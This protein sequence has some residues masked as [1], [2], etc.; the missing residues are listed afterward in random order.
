[1]RRIHK[2]L[3]AALKKR[4]AARFKIIKGL[5]KEIYNEGISVGL[6]ARREIT[7]KQKAAEER[8]A[9]ILKEHWEAETKDQTNIH[10]GRQH[11]DESPHLPSGVT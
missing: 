10:V 6:D 7:E 2:Q 9:G 11:T 1:M 4:P 8:L 3:K 5:L